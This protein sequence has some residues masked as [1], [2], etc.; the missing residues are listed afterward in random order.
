MT[1]LVL[2]L[3]TGDLDLVR[4]A[5]TFYAAYDRNDPTLFNRV[6]SWCESQCPKAVFHEIR[7]GVTTSTM[8]GSLIET[9]DDGRVLAIQF[10]DKEAATIFKMFWSDHVSETMPTSADG[11]RVLMKMGLF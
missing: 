1:S 11:G 3:S 4:P 5:A 6:Q 2:N 10:P 8:T 7:V 9:R